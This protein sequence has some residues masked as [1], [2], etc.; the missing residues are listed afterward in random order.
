MKIL[1][2]STYETGVSWQ[3]RQHRGLMDSLATL[4]TAMEEGCATDEVLRLMDFLDEY[5]V[6]HFH[7]EEQAMSR[8]AY[9][10]MVEHLK[11]HTTYIERLAALRDSLS[12]GGTTESFIAEVRESVVEW[13]KNHIQSR[14]VELGR[15]LLKNR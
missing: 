13:F 14:D 5:V 11:E 4:I 1:L 3:D 6:N 10:E 2:N 8:Y 12:A 15:Y 9:P 7:D